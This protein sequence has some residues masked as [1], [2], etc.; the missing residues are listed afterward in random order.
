MIWLRRTIALFLAL[1]AVIVFLLMLVIFRVDNTL[2][3]P[4]FYNDQLRQADIYNFI[5]DDVLPAALEEA[6]ISGDTS[7]DGINV[8]RFKPHIIG[9]IEQTLPPEWLQTQVEQVINEVVPYI[10][11]DTEG[12]NINIPL[13]DRVE[14]AAQAT[15]NTLHQKEMFPDLYDQAINLI[16]EQ[17]ASNMP[18]LPPAFAL[19]ED[20]L[21]P[22][23]R[24]VLPAEWVLRQVDGAIDEVVPYFTK[25]KEQFKVQVD[26]SDRLDAVEVIVADILKRPETYDYLFEEVVAPAIKQNTQEIT[27]LPIGVTLTDEEILRATKEVLPLEWYQTRVTD[28]VGQIFSYFR[29]TQQ[30]L[31]VVIPL[32]DRK[33]AVTS[34]LSELADQKLESLMDSLPPCTASQLMELL[35][36]PSLN[37]LPACRPLDISY[38]ELKE[39]LGLD[40]ST[41]LAPFVDMWLPD[42]WTFTDADLRQAL[43]G[44]GDEDVLDQ[45]RE[46]V[47]EGLAY[48]NEDLQADL[49][50]DYKTM[51]DIRQQIADGFIFTEGELRDWM[52]GVGDGNAN[53]QLQTFDNVRSW[54]G[55]ARDWKMAVWVIPILLLLAIGF[56]GGRRWN[57]KLLWAAAV[58]AIMA[59]IAYIVFG[60][61]FSAMVQPRIGEAL[62]PAV[63]QAEGLPALLADKGVTMV[64]NAAV[65]FIGGIKNQAL[66]LLGVSLVLIVLGCV[67]PIWFRRRAR[68][69]E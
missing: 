49:G 35:L 30:T 56:L 6:G 61:L 42:Q 34:V 38:S 29:G 8:S 9:L 46:W 68:S 48:T 50:A 18:E 63:G 44:E 7:E 2:G 1:T 59:I 55:T 10:W 31:E 25:D 12:F 21:E 19:S 11:G 27:H 58:L 51:E 64:Q 45:A 37:T 52:T 41:M 66:I 22:I 40:T 57:S 62:M 24:T 28:I 23:L 53:E 26:I 13:K 36:N 14:A 47:Q 5:Y 33:P 65:S 60:P 20:E 54:L 43:G 15:K 69:R 17:A 32:A 39:L 16:L 67:W 4:D 3:N